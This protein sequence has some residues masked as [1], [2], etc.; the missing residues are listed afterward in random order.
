M[1]EREIRI[2]TTLSAMLHG[3]EGSDYDSN[4][5]NWVALAASIVTEKSADTFLQA[6][7]LVEDEEEME[8][9]K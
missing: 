2:A 6:L 8:V 5:L 3:T 7:R 9:V 4:R 1:S